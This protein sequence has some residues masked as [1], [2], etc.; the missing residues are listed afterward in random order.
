[1]LTCYQ[2]AIRKKKKMKWWCIEGSA[3]ML[4]KEDTFR[5][6][7]YERLVSTLMVRERT[8][9]AKMEKRGRIGFGL[10]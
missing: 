9:V 5:Q 10:G 6:K 8:Q 3:K 4:S 7:K 1:M 2:N